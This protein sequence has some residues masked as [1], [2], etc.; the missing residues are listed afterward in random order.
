MTDS[1]MAT[2]KRLPV[3]FERGEGAWLW[4]ENGKRYLDALSGIA[5]CGLGHAHPTV[6]QAISQQAETLIHTSNLYEI[7][8][9]SALGD[10]LTSLAKMDRVFFSNSG[11]EAN[12]AAIKIARLYGHSKGIQIPTIIVMENSF[13]GRTMATLSATGNRKVQAGFEPLVQGFVRVP[14]NDI[15]SLNAVAQANKN[16]VAVLVEPIQGEGGIA[17]PAADYLNKIRE[18]C[19][20]NEWLMML[21]E[22]QTGMGRTGRMFAHQHNNI[23]PDVM[24]LAKALGNGMPIGACLA[25]GAAAE[26]L[27]PGTH[28]STFGGNPLACAA[29]SAVIDTLE[30]EQLI[31]RAATL[32][33]RLLDGFQERLGHQEG[34]KEIR[35]CGLMIGIELDRPC[36]NLVGAALMLGK[37]LINVTADNVIRLLPPLVLTEAQADELVATLSGII[38]TFLQQSGSSE[39]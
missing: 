28:G 15:E 32:G 39:T 4:D 33:T 13:H 3:C 37:I 25:K 6:A 17:I 20:Q 26:I 5:V 7:K 21:D 31:K 16:I 1:L 36:G 35:G 18:L 11:A 14:F 12:E 23:V 22:V 10:R 8:Q 38:K 2:Y 29:A 27:V 24:T 30:K 9:Q 19:D 34:I